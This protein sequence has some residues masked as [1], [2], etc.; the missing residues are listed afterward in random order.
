M[1]TATMKSQKNNGNDKKTILYLQLKYSVYYRTT[2][3]EYKY[4]SLNNTVPYFTK[5]QKIQNTVDTYGTSSNAEVVNGTSCACTLDLFGHSDEFISFF[6]SGLFKNSP[7]R[8]VASFVR[9]TCHPT[10]SAQHRQQIDYQYYY[11][12]T[13]SHVLDVLSSERKF[14]IVQH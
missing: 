4:C 11:R 5:S 7:L 6:L 10:A 12:S 9:R 3:F 13:D 1:A 14:S 2:I 8:R